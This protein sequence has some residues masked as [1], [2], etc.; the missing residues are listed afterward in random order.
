MKT[1]MLKTG[2][3]KRCQVK[4]ASVQLKE[5][6]YRLPAE[7]WIDDP[8]ERPDITGLPIPISNRT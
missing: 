7:V 2:E 4:L 6:P 5:C 8:S 1:S 3:K